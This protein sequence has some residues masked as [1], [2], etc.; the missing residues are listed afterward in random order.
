MSIQM[1][2]NYVVINAQIHNNKAIII[3]NHQL[4]QI[5]ANNNVI[6]SK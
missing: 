1:V 6:M 3:L 4:I 2:K 5:Y